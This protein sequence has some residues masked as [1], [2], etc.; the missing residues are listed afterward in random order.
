M[1]KLTV[2]NPDGRWFT[3]VLRSPGDLLFSGTTLAHTRKPTDF[4]SRGPSVEIFDATYAG[5][6]RFGPEGLGQFVSSYSLDTLTGV[7]PGGIDMGGPVWHLSA[8]NVSL[9]LAAFSDCTDNVIPLRS[10]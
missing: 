5:D 4:E 6:A 7:G 9:I 2:T 1:R 8:I 10:A 3:A